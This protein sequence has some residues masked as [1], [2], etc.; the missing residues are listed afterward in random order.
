MKRVFK[1][2]RGVLIRHRL[3]LA[4][5]CFLVAGSLARPVA[6]QYIAPCGGLGG[7][8]Y[9]ALN[10]VLGGSITHDSN[11]FLVPGLLGDTPSEIIT[12]AC[13]GLRIDKPYAQQRF[14][15]DATAT[16]YRYDKFSHLNFDGLDYRAAWYWHLTPRL[17]G[18]LSADRTQNPTQFQDRRSIQR[19]VTTNENYAFNLDGWLFGGWHVLLGA[20]QSYRSSEQSALEPQ[21]DFRELRGELGVRY[22]FQ[23]GSEIA[24][25]RRRIEGD[26][27]GQLLYNFDSNYRED[28]SELKAIWNLSSKSILTGR[29]TYLD[30]RYD[31]APQR[32]FYGSAG[33]LG[34]TWLPTSKLRL[35]LFA[36][37]N[38]VPWQSLSSTYR[39][40]NTLSFA[41]TWQA[42]AK[43]SL[44]MSLQRTYDDYP[45]S[46]FSTGV[47]ERKDTTSMA[48]LGLNWLPVRNVS[49]GASLQREQRSSNDPLVEYDTT[50][51][52]ISASLTF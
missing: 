39:V 1:F 13:A 38:I 42:T 46:S 41:P 44:Y 3:V 26:Q 24:A 20:S 27:Y 9:D 45:A 10:V 40:S 6:A 2:A 14:V 18:T 15:L 48:V 7:S 19:N 34:Y 51:A 33:E 16:A 50:I 8:R 37:R 31:Q 35:R 23:S 21:P 5:T 11:L 32:D 29:L 12:T 17:S 43:T 30:R 36:T 4:A 47:P 25:V 52:S 28:D 49:V 22:L